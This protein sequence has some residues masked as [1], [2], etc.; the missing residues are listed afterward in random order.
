MNGR[1][2][3]AAI[4]ISLLCAED[5]PA[6][7]RE[8]EENDETRNERHGWLGVA[9]QD[10][11]PRIAREKDLHVKSGALVNDV[12]ED[13][14]A[15]KAGIREDDVIVDFNGRSIEESDDL[16]SAIRAASPGDTGSVTFYRGQ[17]KK[18]LQVTLGKAPRRSFAFSFHGPGNIRI[19]R[20]APVPRIRMFRSRG[21]LG[22]T[23]SD[24]N[25][26]LGEYFGAPEGRGVLV[27]EVQRKSAGERRGSRRET[28]S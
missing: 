14:P 26:Q 20:I 4:L 22:L 8:G 1:V 9:I 28:S 21:I 7:Q 19:P 11:T 5:S 18:T 15:E 23:L 2:V 24:L 12:T 25:P 27:Q 10:V 16:L 6:A 13:S 17:E 3:A